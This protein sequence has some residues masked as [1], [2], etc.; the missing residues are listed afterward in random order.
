MKKQLLNTILIIF[1]LIIVVAGGTYAFFSTSLS[2]KNTANFNT[3]IMNIAY[4]GG[5]EISGAMQM[6]ATREE[7][8]KT[9]INIHTT[10]NSVAPKISLFININEITE[11]LR[12]E[13]LIWE[14]CAERSGNQT[15]CKIGNFRG[16]NDTNNNIVYIY[17][18]YVLSSVNTKF[19]VYVW[20]DGSKTDE[21][22]SGGRFSGY[23]GARS[24]NFTAK[25]T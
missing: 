22:V 2:P 20:L 21:T 18:D 15:V 4:S 8:F 9:E 13:G 11:N 7:G 3:S 24:E 16:Y 19:T 6:V 12:I 1:L 23:I 17:P 14:V 10:N 25:F 5:N